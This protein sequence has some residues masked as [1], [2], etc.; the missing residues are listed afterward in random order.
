MSEF[1]C[2]ETRRSGLGIPC[3]PAQTCFR[4]YHTPLMFGEEITLKVN[5]KGWRDTERNHVSEGQCIC[6]SIFLL[7]SNSFF[8]LDCLEL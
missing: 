2:F 7:C 3:L 5:P 6:F 1:N 8:F 4:R